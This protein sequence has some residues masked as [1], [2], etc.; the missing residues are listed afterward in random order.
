MGQMGLL[1]PMG[2]S[3]PICPMVLPMFLDP[4]IGH[5]LVRRLA[6]AGLVRYAH[7]RTAQLDRLDVPETQWQTLRRLLFKARNTTFGRRHGF[8]RI[9]GVEQY[10]DQVPVR[11]YEDFWRDYWQAAFPKLEG[12]TW[13]DHI[14]YYALSSGTTGGT[15]KYIPITKEMLASNRKAAFTSMALFRHWAPKADIFGGRLFFMG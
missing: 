4:L 2:R 8:D 10:Q 15:T 6:D 13:P 11:T 7:R 1:R 12:T 3:S 5:P 14:P 9:V